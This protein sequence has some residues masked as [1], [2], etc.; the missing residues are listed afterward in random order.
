MIFHIFT[1]AKLKREEEEKRIMRE[2]QEWQHEGRKDANLK[3]AE[4]LKEYEAQELES[5]RVKSENTRVVILEKI[6]AF[7]HFQMCYYFVA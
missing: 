6:F 2:R 3:K 4:S 1:Q 7:I 5:N